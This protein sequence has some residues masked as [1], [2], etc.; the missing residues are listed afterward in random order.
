MIIEIDRECSKC[1]SKVKQ[2]VSYEDVDGRIKIGAYR[3]NCPICSGFLK[4]PSVGEV[5]RTIILK[6]MQKK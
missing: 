5:R 6:E 3:S 1:G 4:H 2:P